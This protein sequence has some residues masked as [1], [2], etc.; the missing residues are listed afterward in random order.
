MILLI[1]L[2]ACNPDGD[3]KGGKKNTDDGDPLAHHVLLQDGF[4]NVAHRGGRALWPEHTLLA[5]GNALDAGADVIE[6]DA[7][8]SSDGVIVCVHDANLART[9]DEVGLLKDYTIDELLVFDAGYWFTDDDSA[10]FPYRGTGLQI[11]TLEEA[12]TAFGDTPISIEIKQVSPS[13]A[14][15]VADLLDMHDAWNRATLMSFFDTPIVEIREREPDA[16]TALTALEGADFLNADEDY[17]PPGRHLHA[18]VDFGGTSVSKELVD[19]AHAHGIRVWMWT[20]ND[21]DEISLF[22]DPAAA[23]IYTDDPVLLDL[24]L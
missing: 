6:C 9:T 19:R 15:G 8:A 2:L 3:P 7:H 4:F 13:I 10:T 1:L 23:E 14:A 5:Y 20:I 22:N 12:L 11:A 21:L 17:E 24:L 16:L 18:P